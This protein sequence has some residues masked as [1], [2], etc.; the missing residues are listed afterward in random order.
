MNVTFQLVNHLTRKMT[1]LRLP[2]GV[3]YTPSW[4]KNRTTL[5]NVI[6]YAPHPYT[7]VFPHHPK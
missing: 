1:P 4:K 2:S 7:A 3:T 6:M 5:Q